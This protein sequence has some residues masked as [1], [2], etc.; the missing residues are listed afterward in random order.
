MMGGGCQVFVP[1][2]E[3]VV[4]RW[5]SLSCLIGLLAKACHEA[6]EGLLDFVCRGHNCRSLRLDERKSS[7][8]A[9][10]IKPAFKGSFTTRVASSFN[11]L[12]STGS[13]SGGDTLSKILVPTRRPRAVFHGHPLATMICPA[14]SPS[15]SSGHAFEPTA[16]GGTGEIGDQC[17]VYP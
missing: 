4:S 11:R 13:R 6:S 5:T 1:S 7:I 12:S 2:S 16:H 3:Q 10:E 9:E 8:D 17:E 15:Y 14:F